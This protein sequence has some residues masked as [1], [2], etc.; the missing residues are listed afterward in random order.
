MTPYENTNIFVTVSYVYI[1]VLLSF[2]HILFVLNIKYTNFIQ[3][4]QKAQ[5]GPYNS[6]YVTISGLL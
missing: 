5:N 3:V 4:Q 2:W 1:T 6:K